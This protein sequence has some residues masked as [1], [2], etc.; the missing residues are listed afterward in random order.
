MKKKVYSTKV[1]FSEQVNCPFNLEAAATSANAFPLNPDSL[2][3]P[4]AHIDIIKL[5]RHVSPVRA[6]LCIWISCSCKILFLAA[7]RATPG[8]TQL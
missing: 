5:L 1:V 4:S 7:G 8:R 2:L 3:P 6:R